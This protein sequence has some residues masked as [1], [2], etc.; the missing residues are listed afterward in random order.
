[1]KDS[2]FLSLNWKDILRG[3]LMAVL[4]PA[5]WIIQQS[6]D[7]GT[8]TLNW[9]QIGMASVAGGLSYLVK[10]FLSTPPQK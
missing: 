2:N 4:T 6:I 5:A 7:A 3:L 8:L 10:N 9:K 1:M